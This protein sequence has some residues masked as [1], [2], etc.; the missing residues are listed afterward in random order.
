MGVTR[1]AIEQ[2][3]LFHGLIYLSPV[4]EDELFL[5][6]EFLARKSNRKI[7]FLQGG[8]DKRI[9]YDIVQGTAIQL[10]SLGFD[11]RLKLYN[12]EDHYLLFS[13]QDSLL[14]ELAAFITETRR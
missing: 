6:P 5:K 7:L 8:R 12:D 2:P 1:A 9:P 14:T 3:Q 13:Q 10:E 11:V 4:T